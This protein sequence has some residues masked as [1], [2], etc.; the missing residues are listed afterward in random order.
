ML[1]FRIDT[2]VGI[3]LAFT[4][5][6]TG[7]WLPRAGS[8]PNKKGSATM[9]RWRFSFICFRLARG[10]KLRIRHGWMEGGGVSI[11]DICWRRVVYTSRI[12]EDVQ[13]VKTN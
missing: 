7:E 3:L 6:H 5:V 8:W 1:D 11:V 9:G 10:E 13:S 2:P 4:T 12:G